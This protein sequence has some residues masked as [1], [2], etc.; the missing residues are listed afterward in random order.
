VRSRGSA[1]SPAPHLFVADLEAY[2]HLYSDTLAAL[3]GVERVSTQLAMKTVKQTAVPVG[4]RPR[5][6]R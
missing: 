2:E 1:H 4:G 3:P 5:R 6:R